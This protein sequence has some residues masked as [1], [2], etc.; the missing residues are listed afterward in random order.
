PAARTGGPFGVAPLDPTVPAV[1]ELER[2]FG[3]TFAVLDVSDGALRGV[4]ADYLNVDLFS[5]LGLCEEVV[6]RGAP[7]VLEDFAPLLVVGVPL[8]GE[9]ELATCLA[10]T[11][12]LTEAVADESQLAGAAQTLGIA[13]D[14][15][16][17]WANERKVWPAHAAIELCRAVAANLQHETRIAELKTQL[18]DVSGHLLSTFEELSLLHRLTER[19]SLSSGEVE[20]TTLAVQ[21]LSEV[22]PAK[23][24]AA[25]LVR[26]GKGRDADNREHAPGEPEIVTWGAS[27]IEDNEFAQFIERLGPEADRRCIVLNRSKTA[28]PTWFY[29]TVRDLISVPIRSGDR[30]LGHLLAFNNRQIDR[31]GDEFGTVEASLLSSVAAILGVHAGNIA[32]YEE[33]SDF[34]GSVIRSLSSAIDAK[35]PY[36]CGHSDRVGR[37]SVCLARE[38][39][40]STEELNTLYLSGLLHDIGKIGIDDQVLRKPGKLT[41]EEYEHIKT[42]PELG[43]NIL[44]GVRQLDVVLPIVLH[45]HEAWDGSG[46]PHGLVGEECPRLARIVAVA[47]SIDAMGSDRPYRKGMPED[48]LANILS[49]GAGRQWDAEVIDAFLRVRDEIRRITESDR[50]PR[51]LDVQQWTGVEAGQSPADGPVAGAVEPP[52]DLSRPS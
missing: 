43:Y 22:V 10:V 4:S 39:G 31:G 36:T 12:L 35:D 14:Q 6:R 7:E 23:C 11:T 3:Q 1:A 45:H 42:H 17:R 18:T 24:L 33:Q 40:C 16:F 28:S 26:G 2:A 30:V 20:L 5:R 48:R 8:Q 29:P 13:T 19:L 51:S 32:L 25:S 27:P 46:Y 37:I 50:A 38:L 52:A 47:D 41:K 49:E 15:A 9:D 21:W 44:K 34:F